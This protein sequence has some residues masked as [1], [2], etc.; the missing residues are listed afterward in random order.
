MAV[1][2]GQFSLVHCKVALVLAGHE[3]ER[4]SVVRDRPTRSSRL[5]FTTAALLH[6]GF[7][8]TL[9]E[10]CG[11][12]AP[13]LDQLAQSL[14]ELDLGLKPISS[15]ALS[16]EPMRFLTKVTPAGS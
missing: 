9:I 11:M 13:P 5:S 14:V 8:T 6:H 12:G 15:A 4:V 16:G 2:T 10:L 7:A 3:P 1:V